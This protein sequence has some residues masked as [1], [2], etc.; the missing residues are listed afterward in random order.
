MGLE[1]PD[2]STLT[3]CLAWTRTQNVRSVV[4]DSRG[5]FGRGSVSHY[6]AVWFSLTARSASKR[7][8]AQNPQ[9]LNFRARSQDTRA[10]VRQSMR[11]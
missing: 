4:T 7:A 11:K 2:R 10:L 5:E 3:T 8:L 1:H 9:A 6:L